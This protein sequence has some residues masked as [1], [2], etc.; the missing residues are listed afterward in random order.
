MRKPIIEKGSADLFCHILSTA[1][2]A[3]PRCSDTFCRP[4]RHMGGLPARSRWRGRSVAPSATL[5][6][7]GALS[8]ATAVSTTHTDIA[9]VLADT[10]Y[11]RLPSH[12][13]EDSYL[14]TAHTDR[15]PRHSDAVGRDS[16]EP[17]EEMV[18]P[19]PPRGP[20]L[21]DVLPDPPR[22]PKLS[23]VA[24]MV[25]PDPPK[26]PRL[27]DVASMVLPDP[28]KGPR[29][30]DVASMVLPDPPQGPKLSKML[31][32]T[33]VLP[34]PPEGPKLSDVAN[35]VLPDP[36]TGPKLSDP[37]LGRAVAQQLGD[38]L[39]DPREH[40][41]A[42]VRSAELML[43]DPPKGPKLFGDRPPPATGGRIPITTA[44]NSSDAGLQPYEHFCDS[45]TVF[46]GLLNCVVP[47]AET[48][49]LSVKPSPVTIIALVVSICTGAFVLLFGE[50][51]LQLSFSVLVAAPVFVLGLYI[52]THVAV[53]LDGTRDDADDPTSFGVCELPIIL[54]VICATLSTMTASCLVGTASGE[55]V[56]F[57]VFGAAL[58]EIITL[59]FRALIVASNPSLAA[60][61]FFNW[62]W[63]VAL[64]IGLLCGFIG[65]CLRSAAC[66][67]VRAFAPR[68][69]RARV[70]QS[71]LGTGLRTVGTHRSGQHT[72]RTQA[73][74]IPHITPP[75]L[76]G[77]CC[78]D[79]H[80]WVC[81][82]RTRPPRL[83]LAS[84]CATPPLADVRACCVTRR[85]R[86]R[87]GPTYSR[88]A[89]SG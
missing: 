72:A 24:S 5:L 54:A 29:L 71:P 45:M 26:G 30:S 16:L 35:A 12:V 6:V 32:S 46:N 47:Y 48:A 58:G 39:P 79:R 14:V 19:D 17:K 85:R 20:K 33:T 88:Q 36:P 82:A 11:Q 4:V 73:T 25:L 77:Y 83:M 66:V 50:W 9:A 63:T 86:S 89:S 7:L 84:R 3:R 57:F 53:M 13:H 81:R 44:H 68:S 62:Y 10:W 59:V 41:S 43:P 74:S 42:E 64:A 23:D 2:I 60:N 49:G 21:S 67:T 52:F 87:W 28:P 27:S 70:D 37:R 61:Q 8:S 75:T 18:V 55:T 69:V 56:A 1:G 76:E 34:D 15:H 78:D 38:V 31:A 51:Q 22:G 65:M 40:D 80:T